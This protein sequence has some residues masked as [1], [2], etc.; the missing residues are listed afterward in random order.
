MESTRFPNPRLP[1]RKP[2]RKLVSAA[3]LPTLEPAAG[4]TIVRNWCNAA[5]F[6][7]TACLAACFWLFSSGALAADVDVNN[8]APLSPASPPPSTNWVLRGNALIDFTITVPSQTT[9]SDALTI[10]AVG[11]G[12]EIT[13]INLTSRAFS[14]SSN[15]MWIN[16]AGNLTF[17]GYGASNSAVTQGSLIYNNASSGSSNIYLGTNVGAGNIEVINMTTASGG[18]VA[19]G[20]AIYSVASNIFVGN[21]S[22]TVTLSDNYS[23]GIAAAIYTKDDVAGVVGGKVTI[24]GSS[25]K[26][27][28]NE[29]A[30]HSGA[31]YTG[32]QDADI[33]VG[34]G[35]GSTQ[36]VLVDNNTAGG[37]GGAIQASWGAITINAKE[38]TLTGNSVTGW[39]GD[40]GSGS[41]G[42]LLG[43]RVIMIGDANSIVTITNNEAEGRGGAIYTSNKTLGDVF[44]NGRMINLSNNTSGTAADF[45]G[46]TG[47]I[48]GGAI[49]SN[50]NIALTG[51]T[52]TLTGNETKRGSGGALEAEEDIT[53]TGSMLAKDNKANSTQI[54]PGTTEGTGGAIWAGGNVTLNA[55]TGDIE[56]YNNSAE[57]D[58]GAVRVG[59]DV[60]LNATGGN[61]IFKGNTA[62]DSGAAIWFNNSQGGLARDSTATFNAASG[63]TITFFDSIE[64]N[65][66]FGQLTVNKTG[67]GAVVFD[68]AASLIQGTTN[69]QEGAFVIRN[70]ASYGGFPSA[71][72]TSFTVNAGAVLAGGIE[73]EVKADH[74]T[75]FGTLDLSGSSLKLPS[76]PAA[77][78]ASG[79]YSTFTLTTSSHTATFEDGSKIL[80]NTY[81][82]NGNPQLTDQLNL[83]LNGG[84][85]VGTAAI[86]VNNT[87]GGGALTTGDGIMLVETLSGTTNGAFKLGSRVV[88]GPYEYNLFHGG[89]NGSTPD[90]WY[91][92][93]E[94]DCT[95]PQNA[96]VCNSTPSGPETPDYRN[97]TSTYTA[98]P[99][100]ALLY[101]RG[102]LDTL[103][104]RVGEEEDIRGR[105]DLH[106]KT[107]DTGGWGRVFGVHGKQNGDA[108]GIY[109]PSGPQYSY[110]FY[111][112]Q[113]GQDLH[114][115][116]YE[117]G[118]RDHAGIYF[119]YG[120]ANGN[121]THFNGET[122]TNKFDAYTLGGYWTRFWENG[123]YVD[124]VLQGTYY[125][126]TSYANSGGPRLN[127]KGYGLGVSVE[128]GK[129]YRF[130]KGYFIEPQLQLIYQNI[131]LDSA[132]DS[133][134]Q[135]TFSDVD[136]LVG[137]VGARIGR[138]W[139]LDNGQQRTVWVR[140]SIFH[141]FRGDPVTNFSSADGPV[142]FRADLGGTWSEINVGMSGQV[143]RSTTLFV[144]ASY[145]RRFDGKGYAYD[146]KIGIRVSW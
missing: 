118:R 145:D 69:V 24:R 142:P 120:Q 80:F 98:L 71:V 102:L 38:I 9:A 58:G 2:T 101:G 4:T 130:D 103:H 56:F 45:T 84:A 33:Y 108:L 75:L 55:T 104:E 133:A 92:R 116:E 49:Y 112:L 51:D 27:E 50:R 66:A 19:N 131:N 85:A 57:R 47:Y 74:F 36:T 6:S 40:A 87:G 78:N 12:S 83:D 35:D 105:S 44:I 32:K 136:S 93:S 119:A 61:I 17:N 60:T 125:D 31:I 42:A 129:P 81:L 15:S 43:S 107:P 63:R 30:I 132:N 110:N 109:G 115:T 100:M 22:G 143:S 18:G 28:R 76:H 10:T 65:T 77:G 8:G 137:R 122:G 117:D 1:R 144:N 114:R 96:A 64:N 86:F 140:P 26:V 95:Q 67:A 88:A 53:I 124:A 146:G 3:I 91:L 141:E 70:G 37:S 82:N 34:N 29:A 16:A 121:V 79:G 14:S 5:P 90:N 138:S 111:G 41:G 94:L 134:A 128:G 20:G 106:Q 68:G 23:G 7:L 126:T 135:V 139:K 54:T 39:G 62:G 59:G 21:E 89:L 48:G 25:I 13:L 72:P 73:G 99:S 123:E 97:E 11:G 113:V 52:I 46:Y 127:T